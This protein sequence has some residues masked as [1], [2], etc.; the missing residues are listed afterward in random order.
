MAFDASA[1]ALPDFEAAIRLDAKNGDARNG[2]G[3]ARVRLGQ[4]VRGAVGDAEEAIRLGP[5]TSRTLY[6]AA[7]TYAQAVGRFDARTIPRDLP[8]ATR[9]RYQDRAV[10]L[11]RQA[12]VHVPAAQRGLYWKTIEPDAALDPIRRSAGFVQL[13][14]ENAGAAK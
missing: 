9:G 1:L 6:N 5:E 2:R 3:F 13:I 12:I 4:D 10:Q 11:L 8:L 7:R 14:V